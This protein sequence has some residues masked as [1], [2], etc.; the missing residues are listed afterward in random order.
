MGEDKVPGEEQMAHLFNS[1]PR[2]IVSAST[3]GL[4]AASAIATAQSAPSQ[5]EVNKSGA[6]AVQT[7]EQ[8]QAAERE[9]WRRALITM[10]RPSSGCFTAVF[11]E[12]AWRPEPC[13]PATPHKAYLP[14]TGVMT[15]I[16]T[17]GGSGPDFTATVTGHI[18]QSEGSF[19]SASGITSTGAY[20][21]QLN[22]DF[23]ST[24]ACTGSPG[25]MGGT[26]RGWE[27]FVYSSDGS[28]FIQY[29]LIQWGPGATATCPAPTHTGC[30]GSH[31]FSDGWCPFVLSDG[32]LYC[33]IDA[34]SEPT[35]VTSKS[36]SA[37]GSLKLSG[38]AA[39]GGTNDAI[40]WTDSGTPH[41]SPGDNRFPDLGTQW[42]QAEFN[43]FGD[44]GGTQVA[45]NSGA[46]L[47]VRT[48]VLSGT[49]AG[50]GCALRSFTAESSN[51]TLSNTPPGSPSPTPAPALV[52]DQQDPA[53]SGAVAS[54]MDAVSFGDTHLT[55]FGGLMYD[56]QA[57]GD[58]LL[59][60]AGPDFMVQARQISGAPTWPDASVNKAVAVQ[61]GKN[62]VA[63]C[64]GGRVAVNGKP[65]SLQAGQTHTLPGGG[66]VIR[67]ADTYVVLDPNGHTMRATM[68]P[69][70][71][72]V[73]VGLGRWPMH[74]TGLLAN[75]DSVRVVAARD[76]VPLTSPFAFEELYGHYRQSWQVPP[77]ESILSD[78]GRAAEAGPPKAP[79][80]VRN[81]PRDKVR[82]Y[83]AICARAGVK[84]GPLFDACTID[85]AVI[86]PKAAE[87]YRRAP[88]PVAV[89]DARP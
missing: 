89:G 65:V 88:V 82:R 61:T 36:L 5:T 47:R 40:I 87:A 7:P 56:F 24:S 6:E 55:T 75:Q 79:F 9:A 71:I 42:Q 81:L 35:G 68:Q 67:R 33:A 62:R 22:T 15:K 50:P 69:T 51:L 76:G 66:A 84:E 11:P 70:H 2:A 17:V 20:T 34:G 14:N 10:P 30:D 80:F 45:F 49:T 60:Q 37:V 12:G 1:L 32:F 46:N 13:K 28:A 38:A 72:D 25:G 4:L 29:W 48:E 3:V 16:D 86:G 26:C 85:V 52:F 59:M 64:L 19:D 41:G 27:Q 74:V 54:C 8:R 23:F 31:V 44:G 57:K 21:L 83:E 78:C 39:S 53:P 73:T 77:K 63:V 18:T 58:Y 43:V